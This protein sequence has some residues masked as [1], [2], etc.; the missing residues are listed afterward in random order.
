MLW[1]AVHLPLLSLESFAAT[2]T[3]E[4]GIKTGQ[5]RRC[6]PKHKYKYKHKHKHKHKY[7]H[8]R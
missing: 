2:L 1:V 8:W 6:K 3:H 7:K 5:A 4:T